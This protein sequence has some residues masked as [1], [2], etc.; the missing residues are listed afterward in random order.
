VNNIPTHIAIIMDGNGRWAKGKGLPRIDGHR[1]GVEVVEEIVEE[2]RELGVKNL[3][4]YAFSKENWRRP[5]EE[6]TQLMQLLYEFLISKKEKM[7][8]QG[9]ALRM[10]GDRSRLPQVVQQ[11]L[12]E[13][14]QETSVGQDMNLILALSYGSRDEIVRGIKTIVADVLS[15]KLN[16]EGLTEDLFNNYLDTKGIPD[17]DLVIRTSGEVRVSNFLLWQAAYAEFIFC[18]KNWPDF[19]REDFKRCVQ[20][21]GK[22]ERRY[23]KTGEQVNQ[24]G[25]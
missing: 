20:E 12:E 17:P 14:I 21:F 10:I 15:N 13:T 9:I 7:L 22:R 4:L 19:T 2:A 24:E 25:D 3:T 11:V 18:E 5:T 6:T 23:G 16:C 8:K 1:R